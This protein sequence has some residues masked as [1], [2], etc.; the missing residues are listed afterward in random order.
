[1]ASNHIKNQQKI[2]LLE[3]YG[4]LIGGKDLVK[5]LGFRTHAAFRQAIRMNKLTGIN[6]FEI[7]G[8]R[9]RFVLT[10][11][12]ENWLNQLKNDIIKS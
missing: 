1:M 6:T 3:L 9:G 10:E 2:G 4:P 8:R 5:I 7:E 12:V 11:D